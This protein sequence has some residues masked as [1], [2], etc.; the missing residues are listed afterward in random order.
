MT[1]FLPTCAVPFT[2]SFKAFCILIRAYYVT[3]QHQ[4]YASEAFYMYKHGFLT[5]EKT[6]SSGGRFTE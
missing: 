2:H 1:A 4:L 6:Y 5:L 3:K